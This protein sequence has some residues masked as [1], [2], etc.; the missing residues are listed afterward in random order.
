MMKQV[1]FH[2]SDN[3]VSLQFFSFYSS[4]DPDFTTE[5]RNL[6]LRYREEI[7]KNIPFI[8]RF[9][10][11]DITNQAQTLITLLKEFGLREF[12]TLVGQAPLNGAKVA[13]EG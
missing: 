4:P 5:V 3:G 8:L 12:A 7:N 9:H 13:V 1:T 6:L 10:L 11:S 2:S